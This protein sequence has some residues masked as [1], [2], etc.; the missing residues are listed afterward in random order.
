MTMSVKTCN[1]PG[2]QLCLAFNCLSSAVYV[3]FHEINKVGTRSF[4][5]VAWYQSNNTRL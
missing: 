1:K 3:P 2:P 5:G 4:N